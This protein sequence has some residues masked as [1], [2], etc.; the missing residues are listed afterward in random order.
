MLSGTALAGLDDI[1]V[2]I[3]SDNPDVIR[4]F[5]F[6]QLRHPL[7]GQRILRLGHLVRIRAGMAFVTGGN[8]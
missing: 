7:R 4:R 6:D 8:L 3:Q 1:R 2:Q 5:F